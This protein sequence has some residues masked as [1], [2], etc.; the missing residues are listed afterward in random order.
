MK[1]LLTSCGHFTVIQ[2]F[3]WFLNKDQ[4]SSNKQTN[5]Y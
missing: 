2:W 4:Y 5:L 1:Q 3:N